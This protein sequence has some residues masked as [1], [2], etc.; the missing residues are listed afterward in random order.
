MSVTY[1]IKKNDL[2]INNTSEMT[3]SIN[4]DAEDNYTNSLNLLILSIQEMLC[5]KN[6][7]ARRKSNE[8]RNRKQE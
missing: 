5:E 1:K 7:K 6:S 3:R 2:Y 8:T 4:G